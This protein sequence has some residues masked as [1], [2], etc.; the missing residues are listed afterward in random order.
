MKS[1]LAKV[2]HHINGK[3]MIKYVID[4]LKAIGIDKQVIVVGHQK[5]QVQET[6]GDEFKYAVQSEQLG[7]GHAVMMAKEAIGHCRHGI[8][9]VVCGDTPLLTGATLEQLIQL[10][11]EREAAATVLTCEFSDPTGYGRIV[12]DQLDKVTAIVEEKDADQ[13]QKAIKEINTGTYC[14]NGKMLWDSL[15]QIKPANAQGEYYLTDVIQVLVNKGAPV[16][17]YKID[18][19]EETMGIN[20]KVQLA[21]AGEV[22]RRRKLVSLMES[23]VTIVDPNSTFIEE[24]VQI[25]QDTIVHPFTII[26]GNT[27]IGEDAVVGPYANI[28]NSQ[29]GNQVTIQQATVLDSQIGDEANIGPYAYLRPG[30]VLAEKVKVGDFVEIKNSHIDTGSKIPHLSYIGDA[31]IGKGVNIGAGTITCNYD[32]TNKYKSIIKDGAFIGS[33]TNLVAPVVVGK[34]AFIGAGSTITKDVPEK[35]LAVERGSQT[36][37]KNFV[38]KK[39]KKS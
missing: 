30:T 18:R 17:A 31:H 7:T 26:T 32:G 12:R 33:N 5:E 15:E 24:E 34:E 25:G 28:T 14:F 6:L 19:I 21:E 39:R 36:I 9:L 38:E 4:E 16:A 3:P 1:K 11:G 2:L 29:V 10:H 35:S 20:N 22:L 13:Q 8:I 23:G 27:I 37:I